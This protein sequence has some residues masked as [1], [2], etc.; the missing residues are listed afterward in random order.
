M[1]FSSEDIYCVSPA[2]LF[3][4]VQGK[5]PMKEQ[6]LAKVNGVW[7]DVS[8]PRKSRR[9][10]GRKSRMPQSTGYRVLVGTWRSKVTNFVT[11]LTACNS[12]RPRSSLHILL[13]KGSEYHGVLQSTWSVCYCCVKRRNVRSW[14]NACSEWMFDE[15]CALYGQ[16]AF[17]PFPSAESTLTGAVYIKRTRRYVGGI[18]DAILERRESKWHDVPE[19]WAALHLLITAEAGL[20]GSNISTDKEKQRP[21]FHLTPRSSD[22]T[23]LDFFFREYTNDGVHISLWPATSF[24]F[25]SLVEECCIKIVYILCV[26]S[27]LSSYPRVI[28]QAESSIKVFLQYFFTYLPFR[29]LSSQIPWAESPYEWLS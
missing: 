13:L 16:K 7:T 6:S 9:E 19:D 10:A 12:P 21:A 23:P 11:V 1:E 2:R 15:F 25:L 24:L 8:I 28:S 4:V 22:L 20:L 27:A 3:A 26:Y 18:C 29:Y 5:V 17:G 14:L